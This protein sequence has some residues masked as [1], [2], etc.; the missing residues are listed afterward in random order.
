MRV[1]GCGYVGYAPPPQFDPLL[2]KVI[3]AS[4]S[5]FA[6]GHTSYVAAVDRLLRALDEFHV[7]GLATNLN[8][9]K[10]ILAH[11]AVRAADARTTLLAE[12]PDLLSPATGAGGNGAL[13]LL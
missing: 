9:L 2:A 7:G 1:D 12:H 11:T 8:Q 6:S 13:T 3:A 4:S 10:A 5:S